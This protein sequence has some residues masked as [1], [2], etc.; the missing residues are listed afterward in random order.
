MHTSAPVFG[1]RP[2]AQNT[3][4]RTHARAHTHTH[5][6]RRGGARHTHAHAQAHTSHTHTLK[7]AC[8][9]TGAPP[10]TR[11]DAHR[12]KNFSAPRL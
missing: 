11:V 5:P 7:A 8:T 12:I 10:S 3:H 9:L 1:G 2:A 6:S 4:A